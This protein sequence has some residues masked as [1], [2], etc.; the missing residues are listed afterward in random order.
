MGL[1]KG[2]LAETGVFTVLPFHDYLPVDEIHHSIFTAL[3]VRA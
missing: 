2:G 1:Q 3:I